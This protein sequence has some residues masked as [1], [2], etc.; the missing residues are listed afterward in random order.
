MKI[1]LVHI[2]LYICLFSRVFGAVVF[3]AMLAGEISAFG[4][5]VGKATDSAG[6]ILH[7]LERKP[8]IDPSPDVGSRPVRFMP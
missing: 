8:L 5:D 4:P 7:L 1:I 3:S 6:R 2:K